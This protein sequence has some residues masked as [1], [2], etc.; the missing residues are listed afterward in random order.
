MVPRGRGT[1]RERYHALRQY[2]NGV[3]PSRNGPGNQDENMSDTEYPY[4]TGAEHASNTGA[5]NTRRR[6]SSRK[7]LLTIHFVVLV[8]QILSAAGLVIVA[9]A[10][11]RS[12]IYLPIWDRNTEWYPEFR[13]T[14]PG[15]REAVVLVNLFGM[16]L[17]FTCLSIL[18]QAVFV[19]KLYATTPK[20]S[21]KLSPVRG[22]KFMADVES[23]LNRWRWAEYF[24]SAPLMFSVIGYLCGATTLTE[25]MA[26]VGLMAVTQTFGLIAEEWN[27]QLLQLEDCQE[28]LGK[29]YNSVE[30]FS[31]DNNSSS[32]GTSPT[33][34]STGSTCASRTFP[35]LLGWIPQT[36]AWWIVLLRFVTA[37]NQESTAVDRN[38]NLLLDSDG[39]PPS[40]PGWVWAVVIVEAIL[41]SSFGFVQL[42]VHSRG[43]KGRGVQAE[44]AYGILSGV[45]KILLV[46][47]VFMS[48]PAPDLTEVS[49]DTFNAYASN[50]TRC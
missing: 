21:N 49:L 18:A 4:T 6:E 48:L 16:M 46:W 19:Y 31:R 24:F 42:Y 9:F 22:A 23:G 2:E 7:M 10:T 38:G 39:N 29:E 34:N 44:A 12:L 33:N 14:F 8:L 11:D 47:M 17:S 43:V 36:L 28:A 20:G 3:P 50:I 35:H 41:F 5:T 25:Q 30:E 13:F 32:G 1:T 40:M 37:V 26:I 27:A 45:S 15:K